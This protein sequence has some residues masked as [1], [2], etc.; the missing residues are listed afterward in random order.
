MSG[1]LELIEPGLVDLLEWRPDPGEKRAGE[2][3]VTG[4]GGIGRKP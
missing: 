1:G 3:L 2:P 4:P